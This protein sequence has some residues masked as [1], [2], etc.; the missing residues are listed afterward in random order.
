MA[1]SLT[2]KDV[3][4]RISEAKDARE[5]HLSHLRPFAYFYFSPLTEEALFRCVNERSKASELRLSP[6]SLYT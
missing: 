4:V 1:K 3:I 2:S 6:A 5:A